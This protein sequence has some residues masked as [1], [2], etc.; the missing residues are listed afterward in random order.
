MAEILK[1][2]YVH[3]C[4]REQQAKRDDFRA[5]RDGTDALRKTGQRNLPKYPGENLDDDYP[6]RLNRA[7]IDGL[8]MMGVS[9]LCGKVFDD[10]ILTDGVNPALTPFLENID[11]QGT[12]FNVFARDVFAASFDGF[13]LILTDLPAVT[14]ELASARTTLGAEADRQF[15]M[16]PYARLYEAASVINWAYAANPLTHKRE[17]ILLVL[18]ECSEEIVDRFEH[19]EVIRYRVYWLENG[20]VH[21]ELYREDTARTSASPFVLEANGTVSNVTQIPAALVGEF[22]ND[23]YLLTESRLEIRAYQKESS[24]DVIEYLSIPVF[25]TIGYPDDAPPLALGASTHLRLPAL[26]NGEKAGVGY[27]QIDSAGHEAL[28][29]TIAQIKDTIKQRL[30]AIA[31]SASRAVDKTATESIVEASDRDARLEVWAGDLKDGLE[32]TLQFMAE[33]LGLGEDAGGEIEFQTAWDRAEQDR[34]RDNTIL[35]QDMQ[36]DDDEDRTGNPGS[37]T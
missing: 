18:K 16:R 36:N 15:N 27:A 12:G 34:I 20:I 10:E 21:W 37:R 35:M 7:T 26:P 23:P 13:A 19:K 28:K 5:V 6:A 32:R 11:N 29:T 30:G 1:I 22:E 8:V 25:W 4:Y 33:M 17:L 2:D 9:T 14:D 3:P 24:F 31:D